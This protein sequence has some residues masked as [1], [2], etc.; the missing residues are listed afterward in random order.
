MS[1][2]AV[3]PPLPSTT[4][5]P[6]G[7]ENSPAIPSRIR[8]TSERTGAC[9]W[10]VPRKAA[11]ELASAASCS[12]RTLD[13]PQPNLPSAGSRPSGMTISVIKP[14]D[15]LVEDVGRSGDVRHRAALR[16][17]VARAGPDQAAGLLLLHDVRC[18]ARGPG[19]G[20]H[21]GEHVR[22]YLGE[23]QHHGRPELD[24]R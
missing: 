3:V 5:Y 24:V 7:R 14:S 10:E 2:N 19:A 18:P 6:S 16:T 20:E 9:R 12:G 23:V 8:C 13:G 11:P 4:S 22:G 21:G 17:H 15:F 1:Q